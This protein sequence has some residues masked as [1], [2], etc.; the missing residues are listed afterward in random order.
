MPPYISFLVRL[1]YPDSHL[2]ILF[3]SSLSTWYSS[4]NLV[5]SDSRSCAVAIVGSGVGVGVF[6]G[7]GVIVGE[8]VV[9]GVGTWVGVCEEGFF[10]TM[11]SALG[12]GLC[13]GVGCCQKSE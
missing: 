3:R 12:I 2:A 4:A 13:K 5:K 1:L 10:W 9:V 8:S 11:L 6:V 7:V